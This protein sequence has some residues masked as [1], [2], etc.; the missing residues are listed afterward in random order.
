MAVN[1]PNRVAFGLILKGK[2][3]NEKGYGAR[4]QIVRSFW[5]ILAGKPVSQT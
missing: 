4:L 3:C 5:I 1:C 2:R